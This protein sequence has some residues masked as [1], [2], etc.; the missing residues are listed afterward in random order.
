MTAPATFLAP[1]GSGIGD[2][3]VAMPVLEWLISRG[4]GAVYLVARG[5]RQTGFEQAIPRLAGV[6]REV[7][8]PQVL[9][10]QSGACY[11]NL[12]DHDIQR[13]YDWYGAKFQQDY[14]GYRINDIMREV[15]KSFDV[16]P[17]FNSFP[18]FR[19][20]VRPDVAAKVAIVPGATSNFKAPPAST[21]QSVVADLSARNLSCIMLGEPE[22]SPVVASL[23]TAGVAHLQT[24]AIQDAID[25]LSSVRAVISVDTGLM[26]IA[27]QQG[28]PTVA[29]FNNVHAYYREAPNCSPIFGPACAV[30]CTQQTDVT[31]PYG[32]D[33]K[34]W[35]WWEGEYD[36]CKAA[37]P[38]MTK[39]KA[40]ELLAAFDGLQRT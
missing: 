13:N 25:V 39:I 24:P 33:Y 6:V 5:P 12:R 32:V 35:V 16:H 40:A 11:L 34:E 15:C 18:K 27:V 19:F 31:F 37:E 2:V 3:V 36:F 30:E 20:T 9:A 10:E 28:T 17:D 14:P 38:C 4:D 8:L 22:R 29:I 21:W 23:K 7:D 26:H 1:I